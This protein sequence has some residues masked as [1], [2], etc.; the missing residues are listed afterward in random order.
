M[1]Q[2]EFQEQFGNHVKNHIFQQQFQQCILKPRTTVEIREL[3]S[4]LRQEADAKER[5]D[6]WRAQMLR[7]MI[8]RS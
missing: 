7:T 1:N 8:E 3:A 6:L 5:G 4:L 2:E